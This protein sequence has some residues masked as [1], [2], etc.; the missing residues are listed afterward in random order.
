MK[1]SRSVESYIATGMSSYVAGAA[2][3][4]PLK[5]AVRH[6]VAKALGHAVDEHVGRFGDV[7]VDVD[8]L[9]AVEQI[10]RHDPDLRPLR[11]EPR[12]CDTC[13]RECGDDML[14]TRP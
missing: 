10:C 9:E 7:R 1:R 2:G 5:P 6:A 12:R 14:P 13:P 8:H 4:T 11:A 3:T